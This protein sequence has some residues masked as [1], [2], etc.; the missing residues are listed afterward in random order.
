MEYRLKQGESVPEGVRRMAAEQLDRAL[1][2]LG[3][4]DGERD[5]HVHEARK[6]TKRLRALVR[7]VHRDLGDEVY[8][9]ENQCYRAA[10]Q[11][12]SGLRDA[13][14]L[15]ETLDRLV[16][17]LGEDVPKSRFAR[18]RVWLVERRDRV[19]GQADS[20][21]RAVQ[22]VIAELAQAGERLE[23]WN[24][25]R[26]DWGGIRMGLQRIYARG[27]RDFAA[28][29]ALPSDEA[30]HD[31]RKQVKYLWYH[32]QILENIW[33]SVMRVQAEELDQ[34][35]ELL[36]QDHDLAVLRTTVMAEFP[37]AGATAT[38]MALERR[39]GEVRSRMQGQARLLGER[40]YLERPSEFSRRL[41]GYW[42]VWQAEQDGAPTNGK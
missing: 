11:R 22:E 29:Y 13:T 12:L 20:I 33:P 14:V 24:L 7:L 8:A 32:T 31:W 23:H 17:S 18:V 40:I 27:R 38:L 28:A 25:Q 15:V 37:R 16:E 36:G 9:L 26:P 35:G 34:L 3:C 42:R 21:N 19:Y 39:I 41:R 6:A 10:G 4:Q 5:K 1:E 2:Y 30:F